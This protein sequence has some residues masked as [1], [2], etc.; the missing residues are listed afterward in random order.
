MKITNKY[1]IDY[2]T[3]PKNQIKNAFNKLIFGGL[4]IWILLGILIGII[5]FY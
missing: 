3:L 2:I 1:T 4:I 5:L